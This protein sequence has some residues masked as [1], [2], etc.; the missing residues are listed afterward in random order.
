MNLAQGLS[1]GLVYVITIISEGLGATW[2]GRE[3]TYWPVLRLQKATLAAA[4]T[5]YVSVAILSLIEPGILGAFIANAG[6]VVL[7]MLESVWSLW[8]IWCRNHTPAFLLIDLSGVPHARRTDFER[9][10]LDG[11]S[12]ARHGFINEE[13]A[14]IMSASLERWRGMTPDERARERAR[15]AAAMRRRERRHR[16]SPRRGGG[17][18]DPSDSGI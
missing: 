4:L 2:I 16:R 8:L 7:V 14:E 6:G 12:A 11:A 3:R 17:A 15:A 9:I 1:L 10:L 5:W 13:L 18:P